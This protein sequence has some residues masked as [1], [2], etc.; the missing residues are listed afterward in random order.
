MLKKFQGRFLVDL[1]EMEGDYRVFHLKDDISQ[2]TLYM[3]IAILGVLSML[4]MDILLYRNNPDLFMGT[5]IYRGAYILISLLIM[6]AIRKINKVRAFD[7]L[8]LIWLSLTLFSLL[9]FNFMRPANLL[10]STYDVII[11]FAVYILSPLKI[12]YT[13]VLALGFSAGTLSVDY[14]YKTGIDPATFN[15][16]F[17]A[18][19]LVHI[20]GLVSGIQIQSYRRKSFKAYIQEKDAKEMVAY[21]ANIDSLTKSLTRRHFFNIAESE[22]LRFSRYHRSLSVLVL[23]ADYFKNINDTYGHYVGDLVLRN[24]SLVVLEQKRAQDTFGRLGGEEFSLLLPETNLEQA[25]VVAERVQKTWAETPCNVDGHLIYSTV[26]IGVAE[27]STDDK[28]FEDVL[29]RADRMMYK[30]KESGRNQIA[31]NE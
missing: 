21:L 5:M 18:Q 31:S 26:S 2:S 3:S 30:A 12:L 9:L 11:P 14:F 29:R 1:G 23:D 22:F 6:L 13:F 20:L 15:T 19:I 10:N 24:L 27:A 7:R 25:K 17:T 4:R 8:I 16:L 28:T